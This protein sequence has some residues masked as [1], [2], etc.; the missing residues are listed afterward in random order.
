MESQRTGTKS[1]GSFPEDNFLIV[2]DFSTTVDTG[3]G[4]KRYQQ[5][6]NEAAKEDVTKFAPD[7]KVFAPRRG[8]NTIQLNA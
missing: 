8:R 1:T 5:T 4:M 6:P 3:L 7:G 2:N